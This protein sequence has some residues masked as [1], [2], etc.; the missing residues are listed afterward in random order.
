MNF[1][2]TSLSS[3]IWSI[4]I[5]AL[6]MAQGQA[7]LM[8]SHTSQQAIEAISQYRGGPI[9]NKWR[10]SQDFNHFLSRCFAPHESRATFQE[11]L[12][13]PFLKNSKSE[14]LTRYL[15]V[16]KQIQD[17]IKSEKRKL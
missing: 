13:H 4:G 6:E 10:L 11:L 9:Y 12:A 5:V 16:A 15:T 8:S 14:N 7:P 1:G 2:R 3:D 17:E